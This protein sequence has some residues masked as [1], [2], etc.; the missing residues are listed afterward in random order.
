M[1]AQEE[2]KNMRDVQRQ[3]RDFA[4][5]ARAEREATGSLASTEMVAASTSTF[6]F[7]EPKVLR[8]LFF[9]FSLRYLF[10]HFA[11]VHR[12]TAEG[13]PVYK[14]FHLGMKQDDG[15]TSLC[16]FDCDCCF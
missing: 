9:F 1:K 12:Y 15:G 8:I 4:S 7:Q 16:P 5:K 13:L 3:K 2:E 6:G 14:Y 10:R 11:Q